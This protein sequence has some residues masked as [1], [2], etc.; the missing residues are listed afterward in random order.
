M[1]PRFLAATTYLKLTDAPIPPI[2]APSLV[3]QLFPRRRR[4]VAMTGHRL[5]PR[6]I[7][8]VVE[9]IA[10]S[11]NDSEVSQATSV[12]RAAIR[13]MRLSLEY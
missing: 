2:P 7:R 11:R 9:H 3:L 12:C 6:T 10:A 13:K 5:P 4:P 8:S 1:Q